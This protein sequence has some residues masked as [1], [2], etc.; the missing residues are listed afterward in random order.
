MAIISL[1]DLKTQCDTNNT[2]W[3][4]TPAVKNRIKNVIKNNKLP[5]DIVTFLWQKRELRW[6]ITRNQK[7]SDKIVYFIIDHYKNKREVSKPIYREMLITQ[8][9]TSEYT[10]YIQKKFDNTDIKLDQYLDTWKN[11]PDE[12]SEITG[13]EYIF[14]FLKNQKYFF[15]EQYIETLVFLCKQHIYL[16]KMLDFIS[17]SDDTVINMNIDPNPFL[18]K[19]GSAVYFEDSSIDKVSQILYPNRFK[20]FAR[21]VVSRNNC[22]VSSKAILLLNS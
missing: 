2:D 6:D 18:E 4:S 16:D 13:V 5:E 22:S 15:V 3:L 11:I 19:L 1:K 7:L 9:L 10:T 14:G 20:W 12:M 8:N 21:F 17:S